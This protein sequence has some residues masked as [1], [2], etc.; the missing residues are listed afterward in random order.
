VVEAAFLRWRACLTSEHIHFPDFPF[1]HLMEG[2][3]GQKQKQL[4]DLFQ[5]PRSI[6]AS[7]GS[8]HARALGSLNETS[9]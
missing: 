1:A 2:E 9:L 3:A 6:L 7:H 5:P 4:L 8:A